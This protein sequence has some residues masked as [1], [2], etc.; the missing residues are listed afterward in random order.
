MVRVLV[1]IIISLR[2]VRM[3]RV[4]VGMEVGFLGVIGVIRGQTVGEVE[5]TMKYFIV[6][7]LGSLCFL[8][9]AMVGCAGTFLGVEV[10]LVLVGLSFKVGLFPFHF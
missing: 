3:L 4:W 7:V 6:Q 1:G 8:L 10:I 9:G 2:S 5:S